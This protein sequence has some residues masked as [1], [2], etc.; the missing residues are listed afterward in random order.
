VPTFCVSGAETAVNHDADS[1]RLANIR[2]VAERV[3]ASRD[4]EVFDVQFRR[5]ERGW[6]VR[7]FLDKP[8]ASV[9]VGR[10]GKAVV[11]DG[12]T[13]DDCRFVSTEVGTL[14]DVE[15]VV[16]HRYVLEVSSP[17]LDRPLRG[18]DDYRR[19]AGCLVKM[20]L[21]QPVDGQTAISG[22]LEGMDGDEVV[23]A[24][25]KNKIRR[26]PAG[27]VTRARLEVE[28]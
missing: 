19:F 9:H 11:G 25:G 15:D 3:A 28:F 12:V 21:A 5:E 13:I 10:A 7:V 14:L 18:P 17:G 23:V 4:L 20:V 24:I 22:R 6:V 1:S 16:G 8:G 2:G 27:L 26:F